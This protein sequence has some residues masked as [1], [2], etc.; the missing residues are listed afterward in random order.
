MMKIIMK[1]MKN[2]M[3]KI[4]KK[5]IRNVIQRA[6]LYY[7]YRNVNVIFI[8]S[9]RQNKV[10]KENNNENN[11]ENNEEYDERVNT[12]LIDASERFNVPKSDISVIEVKDITWSDGSLGCYKN[13]GIAYTSAEVP[14]YKIILKIGDNYINYHGSNN[15]LPFFCDNE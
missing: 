1:I 5:Q 12:A 10:N 4:V 11:N 2:I 9:M 14:G 15:N 8:Y 3:M 7:F 13:S 6:N